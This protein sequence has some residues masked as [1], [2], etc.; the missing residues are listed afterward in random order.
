MILTYV[1]IPFFPYLE[2]EVPRSLLTPYILDQ[3]KKF[4]SQECLEDGI[5][6]ESFTFDQLLELVRKSC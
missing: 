1:E 4:G 2:V 6:G 3:I 5:T